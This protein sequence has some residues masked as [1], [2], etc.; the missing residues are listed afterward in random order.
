MTRTA[1]IVVGSL[2]IL[3]GVLFLLDRHWR[4]ID[5]PLV[6]SPATPIKDPLPAPSEKLSAK[7]IV[8]LA[9]LVGSK[10]TTTA[11]PSARP[12]NGKERWKKTS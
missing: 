9:S 5:E 7:Q 11:A 1:N 6:Q 2:L 4:K 12:T 3:A 10:S 8:D